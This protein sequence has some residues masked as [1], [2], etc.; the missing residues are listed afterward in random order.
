[1][2]AHWRHKTAILFWISVLI[3]QGMASAGAAE[4]PPPS[5]RFLM[6]H[7][8]P[9]YE[10]D[11][12]NKRWGWHWTMNHF[13]PDVV[14]KGKRESASL[15]T[16]LIG[17]YDSND[18]DTLECHVLLMKLSGIDG[19]IIDWYGNDDFLDYGLIHRNTRHLIRFVK[20]AGLRYA[21]MYED[22][23]VPKLLAAKRIP[24]DDTVAHGRQILQ[25]MRSNWFNDPAYLSVTGRP[26]FMVFGSGNYTGA[27]WD[28]IFSGITPAPY[29]FT[30]SDRRAPA[31]GGFGWP[32]PAGGTT[33]A[34]EEQDHFYRTAKTWAAFVP[35][36]FPRFDDIYAQAGVHPS[37]GH[38]DD[39]N[40]KMYEE[41]LERALKSSASVIQLVTWNDWGEGTIIEPSIEHGYRDLE[42][43]QRLR[44]KHV[45]PKFAYK[46]Q[47]LTLPVTLFQ[48][49][50]KYKN[51]PASS[52]K[53][54]TI[55][56]HLFAG[57][58]DKAR[59]LLAGFR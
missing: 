7:Y 16:P 30:E 57:R 18:P 54:D 43:T 49:R 12:A 4:L 58:T 10:A 34:I 51:A 35:A 8:M 2:S 9:W 26:L 46:P 37:W 3:C 55:A 27:Q 14:V 32:Q 59:K 19:V 28:R 24:G 15:Y 17:L 42:T 25:W 36:A 6:A 48:L 20:K 38:I 33:K 31:V 21:I 50:K 52:A 53:L 41:T 45:E 13:K 44:R 56:T 11:P 29:F 5:K 23:T 1:M 39:Q 22:Q 47:D 40:G